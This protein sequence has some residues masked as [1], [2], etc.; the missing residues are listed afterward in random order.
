MISDDPSYGKS[1]TRLTNIKRDEPD[2]SLFE[3]PAD[4][5]II[6]R[7]PL[8]FPA[9]PPPANETDENKKP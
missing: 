2:K 9:A 5:K 8:R 3:I 1:T 4:Y 7:E 6:D